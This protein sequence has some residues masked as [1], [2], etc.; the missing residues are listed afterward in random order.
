VSFALFFA[1]LLAESVA[2]Q[3]LTQLDS[4][5][6]GQ[7]A[8]AH[9]SQNA[10]G[11][12][13]VPTPPQPSPLAPLTQIAPPALA[14][15]PVGP[16]EIAVIFHS[17]LRSYRLTQY[18]HAGHPALDMA[19]PAGTPIYATTVGT[20]A[21]T[22]YVLQG[23]GLMVK[24]AHPNGY[25]SYYAHMSAITATVGQRVTNGSQIGRVG[26]TGWATGP[27]LHFMLVNSKG[28]AVNPLGLL[29]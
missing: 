2:M 12:V 17:P 4:E 25:T 20:V 10:V 15:E 5:T 23:G 13:A 11:S 1:A 9:T 3:L 28:V 7:V 6:S 27:H 22:G 18:F 19:A 21:A 24:I 26:S 8:G 14:A 16:Q 29:Q